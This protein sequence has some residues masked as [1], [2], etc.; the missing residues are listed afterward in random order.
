MFFMKEQH[1]NG[2]KGNCTDLKEGSAHE[3]LM[4]NGHKVRI[5]VAFRLFTKVCDVDACYVS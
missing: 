3:D 1:A 4:A 2:P 5:R